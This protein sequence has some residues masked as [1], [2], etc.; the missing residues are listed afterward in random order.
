MSERVAEV[1][2]VEDVFPWPNSD[3]LV[4]IRFRGRI[5]HD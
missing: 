1:F 3:N 2:R 5:T 4:G